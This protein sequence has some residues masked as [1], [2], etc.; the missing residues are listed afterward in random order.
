MLSTTS[1]PP[2]KSEKQTGDAP[3]KQSLPEKPPLSVLGIIYR[4]LEVTRRLLKSNF[5]GFV[6]IFI[7]GFLS[8]VVRS[9]LP[10]ADTA[11]AAVKASILDIACNYVFDICN[12]TTSPE[13]DYLNKPHR[14]IPAGLIT[15]DQAKTRWFVSWTFVPLVL[16]YLCGFWA[17][18]HLFEWELLIAIC[19]VL[20]FFSY[21]MRNFFAAFSYCILGRLLNQVLARDIPAWDLSFVIDFTIFVWFMGTIHVQEFHDLEGDRKS[22]R[23]TLPML[24]SERGVK[25]LRVCTSVFALGFG[26]GLAYLG[27]QKKDQGILIAPISVLQLASS[28][29][30][31]YR[32]TASTS[33]EM[34]RKTYHV[35]YYIPVLFILLSLVLVIE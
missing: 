22:N 25:V 14:P 30:L 29:V 28:A 2:T 3:A 6:F 11:I 24:L 27:Y 7:G 16:Y 4:E 5:I 23:K 9:P 35:Y 15:I 10:V 8:R 34:D 19:Y 33:P 12:Q 20:G 31:S 26:I 13:E 17:M 21:F 18:V 32:I 1:P